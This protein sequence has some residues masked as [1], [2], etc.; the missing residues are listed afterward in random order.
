MRFG[1]RERGEGGGEVAL[2]ALMVGVLVLAISMNSCHEGR[3]DGLRAAANLPSD[4]RI[5]QWGDR[6]YGVWTEGGE[7]RVRWIT[8]A[9]K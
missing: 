1:R 3:R 7:I 2:V 9:G 8:E 4:A 5:A 6:W